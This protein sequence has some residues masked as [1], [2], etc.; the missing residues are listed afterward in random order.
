LFEGDAELVWGTCSSPLVVDGKL[1][2]NPGG[3]EASIV[4]LDPRTG[5]PLWQAPGDYHAY[6]SFIVATLGGQ[7][8]LVGYDR[9]TLGGWDLA[10]GHRL[11]TLK[12]PYQGDFNVPTPVAV[13]GKLLVATE[14]NG[15]RLYG[16]NDAGGIIAEPLATNDDLA[17]DTA[18]PVVVGQRVF[19]VSGRLYCLDLANGLKT[20]W[21][22]KNQALG[23]Y[24]QLFATDD[25]LLVNG[26]G[27]ELLLV[28]ARSNQF[29][30]LSRLAVFANADS[31]QAEL[32]SHP[33]LVGTRLYLRGENEL[34]C[35]E[36][37]T[38]E[39]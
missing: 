29:R 14:N 22:G 12:P 11:W 21:A 26:C 4:A 31:Q 5:V 2:I 39:G 18:S 8:Q 24:S 19:C 36:L 7:R 13:D 38:T 17:P 6:S 33:A 34:V 9:T 37:V 28:D 10:T 15:T 16:F 25:R 1:I 30:V 20:L 3:P 27:G 32:L 23:D 35:I